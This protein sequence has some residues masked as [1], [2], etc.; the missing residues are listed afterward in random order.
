MIDV[1]LVGGSEIVADFEGAP[2]RIQ[3]VAVRAMNRGMTSGRTFMAS[4]IA[5]N[6]GLKVGDVRDALPLRQAT[7]SNQQARLGASLK[8][9][10]L[11]KFSAR[12]PEPSRGL[13]SGVSYRLNGSRQRVP[14]AFIA[15]TRSGHRGV[16]RRIGKS[17]RRSPGAWGK[18][19]PVVELRGPS[20]GAVFSKFRTPAVLKIQQSFDKNF[21]H[22]IEYAL[23][24]KEEWDAKY[25]ATEGLEFDEL[26]GS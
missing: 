10:G 22:E 15:T 23:K 16:F 5:Q 13:G 2:V 25:S 21:D 14:D 17:A 9:I 24:K 4:A 11:I 3:K 18:N 20:L 8:K 26:G 6:I 1:S 12:G 7:F 19:L